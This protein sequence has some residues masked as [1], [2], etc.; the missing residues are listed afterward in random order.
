M[1]QHRCQ[2]I[3]LLRPRTCCSLLAPSPAPSPSWARSSGGPALSQ[4]C[5]ISPPSLP[6]PEALP[7][8][9]ATPVWLPSES[10]PQP[11]TQQTPTGAC[12]D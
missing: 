11:G 8:H 4:G 7:Q 6:D 5:V 2:A 12:V 1:G 9:T 3:S 10:L